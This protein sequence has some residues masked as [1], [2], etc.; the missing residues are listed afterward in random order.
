MTMIQLQC[1][2]CGAQFERQLTQ[3][4]RTG[5]HAY[6]DREC[7]GIGRRKGKTQAQKRSEKAA[8]DKEYRAVNITEIK[9]RKSEYFQK[10]YDPEKA[11]VERKKR[12]PKHVEYCRRPEYRKWKNA[13]DI[14][15]NAKRAFGDFGEAAILLKEIETEVASRMSDYEIR[16]QQGTLNKAQTRKKLYVKTIR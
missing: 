6:C 4:K 12:M 15:Y 10:T 7:A 5:P 8:Y 13:Y 3:Y 1:E 9:L 16:L 2:T 14:K 11:R